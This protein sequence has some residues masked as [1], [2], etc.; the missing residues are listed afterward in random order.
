MNN[1]NILFVIQTKALVEDVMFDFFHINSSIFSNVSKDNE[2]S[3]H[4]SKNKNK[5]EM[6]LTQQ[7]FHIARS[8]Q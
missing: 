8:S 1:N 4:T 5:R 2:T 3:K 6:E 7:S